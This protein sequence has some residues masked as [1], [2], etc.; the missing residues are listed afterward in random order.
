VHNDNDDNNNN[1]R[2]IVGGDAQHFPR[3]IRRPSTAR[4]HAL[5]YE[6]P[7]QSTKQQEQSIPPPRGT[8][9]DYLNTSNISRTPRGRR[10]T[11]NHGTIN[12]QNERR[13]ISQTQQD[14]QKPT[15]DNSA[16]RYGDANR[17]DT[18]DDCTDS[19]TQ[20]TAR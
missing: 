4:R 12:I 15:S 1:K 5:A 9:I 14:A 10:Q 11:S 19:I 18:L 17:Y 8:R 20:I 2:G 3:R 16:N 13:E 6:T 7:K